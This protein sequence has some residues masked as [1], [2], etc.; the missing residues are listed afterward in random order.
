MRSKNKQALFIVGVIVII[1]ALAAFALSNNSQMSSGTTTYYCDSQPIPSS[2]SIALS[3]TTQAHGTTIGYHSV[4]IPVTIAS[5]PSGYV[6]LRVE[7]TPMGPI[8]LQH[9]FTESRGEEIYTYQTTATSLYPSVK[10]NFTI[11]AYKGN[12]TYNLTINM[13]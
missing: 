11:P 8:V 12:F 9:A 3:I 2:C 5:F 1:L 13:N 6:I 7:T 4:A 10:G